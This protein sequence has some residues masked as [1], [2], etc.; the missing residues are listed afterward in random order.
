[1]NYFRAEVM[2]MCQREGLYQIDLLGG[3]SERV[4]EGEYWTKRR[5]Q[6]ELSE[7][8]KP[9]KFE[10]DK[11]KLRQIIRKALEAAANFDKFAELLLREGVTVKQSRGGGYPI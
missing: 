7:S 11:E 4:T 2:D 10:T 5:G 3:S 1:M 6:A 9:T 8:G